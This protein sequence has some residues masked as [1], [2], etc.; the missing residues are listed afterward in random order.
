M[1][2]LKE[3]GFDFPRMHV[4]RADLAAAGIHYQDPQGR[5]AD[6]HALRTTFGTLLTL[7][8]RSQRR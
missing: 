1:G 2:T 8:S 5:V 7:A 3:V 6:F 4:Y